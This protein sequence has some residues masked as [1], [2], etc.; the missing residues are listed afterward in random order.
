MPKYVILYG[1]FGRHEDANGNP[2]RSG[3]ELII[4][5]PGDI[6]ELTLQQAQAKH[7]SVRLANTDEI[8]AYEARIASGGAQPTPENQAAM[9]KPGPLG[10]TD[11]QRLEP[12]PPPAGKPAP[13]RAAPAPTPQAPAPA[14]GAAGAPA[15]PAAIPAAT[16]PK[17]LD[18]AGK[19]KARAKGPGKKKAAGK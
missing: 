19:P 16:A 1:K 5:R 10:S 9:G 14:A 2:V 8:A 15:V 3:G 13:Q 12:P 6:V 4:K 17:P 7:D 11:G 18:T